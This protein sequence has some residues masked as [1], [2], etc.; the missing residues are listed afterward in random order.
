MSVPIIRYEVSREKTSDGGWDE[1]EMSFNVADVTMSA[2]EIEYNMIDL[3]NRQYRHSKANIHVVIST[4]YEKLYD[5]SLSCLSA[6]AFVVIEKMTTI[7]S[8]ERCAYAGP[9]CIDR[10]RWCAD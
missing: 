8:A 1:L 2:R 3:M 9:P 6:S 5:R 7:G 4:W 10:M